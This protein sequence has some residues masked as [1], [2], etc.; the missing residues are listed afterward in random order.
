MRTWICFFPPIVIEKGITLVKFHIRQKY[1]DFTCS[2]EKRVETLEDKT[3]A[4]IHTHIGTR[5]AYV[6]G[7]Q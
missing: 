5:E 2:N 3:K 6:N 4:W 7:G 1:K